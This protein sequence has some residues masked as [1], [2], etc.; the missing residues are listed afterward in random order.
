MINSTRPFDCATLLLPPPPAPLNH[1]QLK[2]TVASLWNVYL[3]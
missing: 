1:L 2:H 3:A